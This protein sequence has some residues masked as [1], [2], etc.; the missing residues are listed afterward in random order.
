M[1]S[2]FATT[3]A[4]RWSAAG[5]TVAR[6]ADPGRL[7]A[8]R[9]GGVLR[10]RH[11]LGTDDLRDDLAVRIAEEVR[12]ATV[13]EFEQTLVG[14][15]RTTVADPD[16]AWATFYR[17]SLDDLLSGRAAFAPV[18]RRAESLH[19]GSSLLELGSCFGLFALRMARRGVRVTASDVCPG[20]VAMLRRVAPALGTDLEAVVADAT[21]VPLP[22]RYA[23]TVAALHLLEHLPEDA[24]EAVISE[25]VRLA[26]RRVVIAVPF[27][28]EPAACYGHVRTFDPAELRRLGARTGLPYRVFEHHGGW[29]VIDPPTAA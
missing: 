1:V 23:D 26:R 15:I 3:P 2:A 18:H 17:N 14:L 6:D 7:A 5:V 12:P 9:S 16:R 10:V 24:A 29:L 25:A 27:E 13:S 11:G 8:V 22:D 20:T 21:A 19:T 28:D 4:G